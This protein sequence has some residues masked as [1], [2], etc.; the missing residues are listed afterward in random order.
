VKKF[1]MSGDRI[2]G[3]G[4]NVTVYERPDSSRYALDRRGAGT[5]WDPDEPVFGRARFDSRAASTGR[6]EGSRSTQ[7]EPPPSDPPRGRRRK[8][9]RL[10]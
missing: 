1:E 9:S 5:E 3:D 10:S 7:S 4:C 2:V 6:W 8:G